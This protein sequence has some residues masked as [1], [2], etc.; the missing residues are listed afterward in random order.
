MIFDIF[1]QS[2][3][4]VVYKRVRSV[5]NPTVIPLKANKARED[6][7]KTFSQSTS[8]SL[9]HATLLFT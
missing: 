1:F 9:S 2:P 8:N 7:L 6:I 4:H 5:G 3:N